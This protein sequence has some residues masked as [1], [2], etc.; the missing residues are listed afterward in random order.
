M[1]KKAQIT[2]LIIIS[3]VVVGAILVTYAIKTKSNSTKTLQ[4][5]SDPEINQINQEIQFCVEQRALDA[6]YLI[7]L[8]GGYINIPNDHIQ[9][10]LSN[11]A[12]GLKNRKNTFPSTS[13]IESEIQDYIEL[14][15]SFCL[16]QE[17]YLQLTI[18]QQ[19]PEA[20][21]N[22]KDSEVEIS[23][24]ITTS[25]TKDDRTYELNHPYKTTIPIRLGRIH[26]T[27]N[28]IIKKHLEDPNYI[29]ITYL[30]SLEYEIVFTPFD[31]QTLIYTIT[32]EESKIN[33]IH[34]SFLFGIE[35]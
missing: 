23:V 13:K 19:D 24:S 7:G 21:I 15:T 32:D 34:Y 2:L 26:K 30:T 9:T 17:S 12:Y 22:I 28:E 11:I 20:D 4:T 6:I 27:I 8:Q 31:D 33:E 14:T 16:N 1:N 5:Y 10:D 35:Q 25:I 29:D 3:I 18:T